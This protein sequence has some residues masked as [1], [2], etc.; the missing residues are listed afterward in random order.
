MSEG[1]GGCWWWWWWW[2]SDLWCDDST[3][4]HRKVDEGSRHTT[5]MWWGFFVISTHDAW[6]TQQHFLFVTGLWVRE[7]WHQCS[8]SGFLATK[9]VFSATLTDHTNTP[10]SSN[11]AWTASSNRTCLVKT[12]QH[13]HQHQHLGQVS[14]APSSKHNECYSDAVWL[15]IHYFSVTV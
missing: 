9:S 13:Q 3:L 10:Y 7:G 12:E 2:R 6:A 1:G 4:W 5:G 14:P 15:F 8:L 11:T